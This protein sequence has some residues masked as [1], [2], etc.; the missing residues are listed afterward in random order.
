MVNPLKIDPT[1]TATIRRQFMAEFN[2]R[3]QQLKSEVIKLVVE[4]DAFGIGGFTLFNSK[5][6]TLNN[7]LRFRV[8]N[9]RW[10][11]MAD[12]EK[13]AAFRKWM[14]ERVDALFLPS[15]EM[16]EP[17][18]KK[19]IEE[20]YGKGIS[21]AFDAVKRRG[22]QIARTASIQFAATKKQF[23]E[24]AFGQPVAQ[25]KI[26]ILSQ[27]VFTD[28]KGVTE[29]MSTN[30]SRELVDGLTRG[31]SPRKVAR[32]INKQIDKV[33][34]TRSVTI[35]R[36]E[37]IRAHAE[38]NLDAM[39]ELGIDKVTVAVEWSTAGDDRVC[40]LCQPLDGVEMSIHE[41]R[42]IL[43][44]HPNCRC[45]WIPAENIGDKVKKQ[46]LQAAIA[47]S[48][49]AEIPKKSKR[50]VAAQKKLSPWKGAKS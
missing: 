19:F 24:L 45:A 41:A 50:G 47:R 11:G 34:K 44:R 13:V 33:G 25:Q 31:D 18:W 22:V 23:L 46:K 21:R 28:L 40:P 7:G 12:S 37:T 8:W 38:G 15:D 27:R 9:T 29:Q 48:V 35:A 26:A 16:T 39:E 20:S 14:A 17:Y 49:K 42:G 3:I 10:A 2:K 30:I 43:P 6:V 1:R 4:E 36:T 32:A 5:M